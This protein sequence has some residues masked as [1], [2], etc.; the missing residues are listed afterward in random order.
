MEYEVTPFKLNI[1]LKAQQKMLDLQRT[2]REFD[3]KVAAIYGR[4]AY[5]C[6]HWH[7]FEQ[8]MPSAEVRGGDGKTEAERPHEILR[9]EG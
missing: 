6:T 2:G 3:R 4:I 8:Y 5:R 7:H 9:E 1:A